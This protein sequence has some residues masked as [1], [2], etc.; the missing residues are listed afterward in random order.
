MVATAIKVCGGEG[1]KAHT[2]LKVCALTHHFILGE[3]RGN[4]NFNATLL[5]GING[6]SNGMG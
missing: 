6:S 5:L 1:V 2:L 4:K 3:K